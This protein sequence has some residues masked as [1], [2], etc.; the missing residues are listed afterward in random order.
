MSK[1]PER[2]RVTR[3]QDVQIDAVVGVD[4]ACKE[5]L[6]RAGVPA[7]DLPARGLA[8]IAKLTKVHN[9]LVADADGVVAGY[10]AWR[11]E[12]P[13]VAYLEEIHVKPDLQRLGIGTKLLDAVR[14]EVRAVSLPVLITRCWTK[15]TA[16]RAFLAKAGL[17][18]LPPADS[19]ERTTT[20]RQEQ[21][22]AGPLVRDGQVVL[23]QP[24]L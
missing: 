9:V 3:M 6:H 10:A 11:D 19:N 15:A 4:L 7:A 5:A 21:E 1:P 23:V 8:G 16:G 14:A 17:A 24:T 22:A 20:W 2:V 18:P 12:S 13:G